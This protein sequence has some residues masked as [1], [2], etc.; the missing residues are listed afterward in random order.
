MTPYPTL[1]CPTMVVTPDGDLT[2]WTAITGTLLSAANAVYIGP[3]IWT[4]TPLPSATPVT[5]TPTPGTAT[6]TPTTAP[7]A[8][9]T[10]DAQAV[11]YCAHPGTGYLALAGVITDSVL[12]TPT[13]NLLLGDAVELR[14]DGAMDGQNVIRADDRDIILGLSG[15][16]EDYF[17]RPLTAT[18]GVSVTATGWQWEMLLP[19]DQLGSG[20]LTTNRVVGLLLGYLDRVLPSE[21]WYIMT[22][23]WFGGV[24]E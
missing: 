7:T 18:I 14:L 6:A 12:Y 17:R 5:S 20:T 13:T 24:M 15:R 4:A 8:T 19:A 11:F 23:R 10:P 2:E 1:L 16:A 22:S 21:R 3:P 9:K